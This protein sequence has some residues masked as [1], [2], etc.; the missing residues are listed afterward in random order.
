MRA[1]W[2]GRGMGR[3]AAL[4]ARRRAVAAVAVATVLFVVRAVF[5]GD[6]APVVA[7]DG[8]SGSGG[9]GVAARRVDAIVGRGEGAREGLVDTYGVPEAVVRAMAPGVVSRLYWKLVYVD[10]VAGLEERGRR[11]RRVGASV[12]FI[13]AQN[14][15]GNRLRALGSGLA[16]AKAT[17]RVPVVVWEADAHLGAHF[18]DLFRTSA[19]GTDIGT[20]L[21]KDLVVMDSF[22]EWRSIAAPRPKWAPFNY[23]EKDGTGAHTGVKLVF[24][25]QSLHLK[26][27]PRFL[28]KERAVPD[29]AHVYL[30][31]AYVAATVPAAMSRPSVVN[32]EMRAL[33]PVKAV[34]DLVASVDTRGA[35]GIHIRSRSLASDNVVVD[36]DC[37]Y[38][39]T[40]ADRTNFWRAR[41]QLPAFLER[42]DAQLARNSRAVFFVAADD[43]SVLR[44]LHDAYPG[45]IRSIPRACDDRERS[46]VPYALAD[47]LC[48]ART[49]RVFGS[50][51]SSFSEAAARLG[52]G[53]VYLSGVHFGKIRRRKGLVAKLTRRAVAWYRRF[54]NP[55]YRCKRRL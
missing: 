29:D 8:G 49:R 52:N 11:A 36:S 47:L 5:G 6:K 4:R 38:T 37:E 46:C 44:K 2:P 30:K 27:T 1:A 12:L 42:M 25:P 26:S 14:G 19:D 51:W 40:G 33:R 9:G 35:V 3:R 24:G 41:S 22:P 45:R 7:F 31:S 15:L 28:T 48:L 10:V 54:L 34:T 32:A 43:V 53:K 18:A 20:V 16:L 50:N 39:V 55:Y 13:H 23:M 17:R 21:Y